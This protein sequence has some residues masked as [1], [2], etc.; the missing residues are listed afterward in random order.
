MLRIKLCLRS[1][2]LHVL[3]HVWSKEVVIELIVGVEYESL[4][5]ITHFKYYY[6]N[7]Q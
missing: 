5:L 6:L 4:R 2:V 7:L 3:A 1:L